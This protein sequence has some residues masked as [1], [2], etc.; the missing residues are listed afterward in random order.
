MNP[1][2]VIGI[3]SA[4]LFLASV[5]ALLW[6]KRS[7]D[8]RDRRIAYAIMAEWQPKPRRRDA[9][10]RFKRTYGSFT[11]RNSIYHE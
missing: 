4:G 10:G 9:Q 2:D 1:I 11:V 6:F 3:V 8:K 7:C 5:V